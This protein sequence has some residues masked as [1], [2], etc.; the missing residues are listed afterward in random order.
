[1]LSMNN[2]KLYNT[3]QNMHTNDN[4]KLSQLCSYNS[5]I[6]KNT[7]KYVHIFDDEMS[8]FRVYGRLMVHVHIISSVQDYSNCIC[9]AYAVRIVLN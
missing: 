8:D 4:N 5:K 7:K 3:I 6:Y 2:H 9:N 1:M